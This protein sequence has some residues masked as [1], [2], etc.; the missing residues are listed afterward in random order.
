[1][2]ITKLTDKKTK[3]GE[4]FLALELDSG[5]KP[6]CFKQFEALWG[7]IRAAHATGENIQLELLKSGAYINVVGINGVALP[8]TNTGSGGNRGNFAGMAEAKNKAISGF[9]ERKENSMREF[10]IKR[11]A[12]MFAVAELSATLVKTSA[13]E[14]LK[15]LHEKWQKY[16]SEIY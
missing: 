14:V 7:L 6:S 10:A 5:E 3:K 8:P 13:E 16:F 12:C 9:V 15:E 1:M 4:D 11:D 2:K